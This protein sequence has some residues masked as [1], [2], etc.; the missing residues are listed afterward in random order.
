[1]GSFWATVTVVTIVSEI[2]VR[3]APRAT[4]RAIAIAKMVPE[5]AAMTG[6]IAGGALASIASVRSTLWASFI[7]A[8]AGCLLILAL[9]RQ[10]HADDARC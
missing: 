3:I 2:P 8:V 7:V 9:A 1:M 6:A 5:V 4:A 10:G